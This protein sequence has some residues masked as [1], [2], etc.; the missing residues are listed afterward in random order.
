[1]YARRQR[2]GSAQGQ[3][4]HPNVLRP[5]PPGKLYRFWSILCRYKPMLYRQLWWLSR[6]YGLHSHL[7]HLL[8]QSVGSPSPCAVLL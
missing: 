7:F 8:S 6:L 2:F 4:G 1:M 3:D 5:R